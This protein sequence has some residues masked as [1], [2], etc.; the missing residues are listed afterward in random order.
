MEYI[1][2]FVSLLASVYLFFKQ[3]TVATPRQE[4]QGSD[5]DNDVD[6]SMVEI[7]H[8]MG[9]H[10][11]RKAVHKPPPPPLKKLP[12][13]LRKSAA[14]SQEQYR[15]ESLEKRQLKSAL[16]K[17]Q[18]SKGQLNELS[19]DSLLT[20]LHDTDDIINETSRAEA[21]VRRLSHRRYLMIYHEIISPP[22][23]MRPF[24]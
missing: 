22:K 14:T 8:L 2:F 15:L 1:G 11:Q 9:G 21:A 16:E 17:R 10:E 19:S 12:K 7:L 4:H 20:P 23:S 13:G 18:L 24:P 3:Q 6:G 5:L